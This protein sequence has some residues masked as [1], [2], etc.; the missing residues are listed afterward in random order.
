MI[1]IHMVFVNIRLQKSSTNKKY[2]IPFFEFNLFIQNRTIETWY[3]NIIVITT[4]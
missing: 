1:E 2:M 4:L 3:D